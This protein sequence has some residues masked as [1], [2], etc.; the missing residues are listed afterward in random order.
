MSCD[1]GLRH[2]LDLALLRLLAWELACA[3]GAALKKIKKKKKILSVYLSFKVFFCCFLGPHLQ[4]MEVPRLGVESKLQLSPYATT[5][6]TWDPSLICDLHDSSEQYWIPD[7]LSKAM[8]QT[9]ILM[10]T[11]WICF[12]CASRE[13]LQGYFYF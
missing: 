5:T 2:G 10:D 3:L 8:D 6:E 4:H 11:S 12:C 9:Q 1:V 7:P 13:T